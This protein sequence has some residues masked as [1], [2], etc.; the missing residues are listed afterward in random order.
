MPYPEED[1][2]L[3]AII[4]SNGTVGA[5][6][7]YLDLEILAAFLRESGFRVLL[8]DG[9]PHGM[10]G[11]ETFETALSQRPAAVY[12]HVPSRQQ[13]LAVRG[14]LGRCSDGEHPVQVAGGYFASRH[15]LAVLSALEGLDAVVHGESEIPMAELLSALA[16]GGPWRSTPGLAVREG[17]EAV[18]NP[19]GRL[20][21]D[22][23]AL[24]IAASDLFDASRLRSGQKVL[25]NRGC[26]SNCAYCGLQVPYRDGFIGRERF[27]RSR[28]PRKI[29][30]E[31]EYYA[32]RYRVRRFVLE[33]F[34]VFGYAAHGEEVIAGV[35]EEIERR[36]LGIEFSFVT[37][38]GA[39]VHCVNLLPELRRA[40]L[41]NL[42]LGIDSGLERALRRYRVGFGLEEVFAAL[43]A[44][45]HH[46]VPFDVGFF[47]IDPWTSF[48]EIREQLDFLR[49]IRPFFGHMSRPYSFFL[50]QQI[51][52]TA[53]HLNSGMPLLAELAAEGL[54]VSTDPLTADPAARFADPRAGRFYAAHLR[55]RKS[56]T[57]RALRPRFL[58]PGALPGG[59]EDLPLTAAEDL[60]D[61]F[62]A[63]PE[64]AME[65]VAE[66]GEAR[67]R[68]RVRTG[69]EPDRG[70][71]LLSELFLEQAKG[72]LVADRV[73]CP[74][75]EP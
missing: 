59:L 2:D 50:D 63:D 38:P 13:F 57:Y 56:A 10:G 25:L 4:P 12:W 3:V 20:L 46:R 64:M 47:F 52:G 70:F 66:A 35:A 40:G 27:W 42:L 69:E 72:R 53:L 31:I 51:L 11:A 28:S 15:D 34:V 43:S 61:L 48:A 75:G 32:V 67:L 39:L 7:Q 58:E 65:D 62:A 18:R 54:L 14:V 30:D 24:P 17:G 33:A 8:L 55:L 60:W 29:V 49:R 19:P 22:L 9:R 1:I 74:R 71:H 21:E 41:Q 37:H 68:E 45:H 36:G 6:V 23:N 73:G 26:N 44:L 16:Q 5:A